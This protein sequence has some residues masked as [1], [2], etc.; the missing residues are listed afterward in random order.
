ML[1]FF[2]EFSF[3]EG[4]PSTQQRSQPATGGTST[5]DEEKEGDNVVDSFEPTYL[6]DA[7]RE[8][9]QLKPLL[10]GQ[11][12]DAEDGR[13]SARPTLE[14]EVEEREVSQPGL[15]EVEVKASWLI[16]STHLSHVY[17]GGNSVHMT[18][19]QTSPMLPHKTGDRSTS[20]SSTTRYAPFKTPS[21]HLTTAVRRAISASGLG[22]ASQQVFIQPLPPVL[23]LHLNRFRYDAAAGGIT[24]IG[25]SIQFGPELE[26]PLDIMVPTSQRPSEPPHYKLYGVL[27]HNG[28]SAGR[29]HY[30]V[31]VLHPNGDGDTGEVWLHIDDE[32]VT[33]TRHEDVFGEDGA[34]R[35]ADERCAYLLFYCRTSL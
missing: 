11:Q 33:R 17:L 35:A 28:E 1:R 12:Q 31:D 23:V 9:R 30:M 19:L 20:T 24:K 5:A 6:Y 4:S 29:G 7:M 21:Q 22:N 14:P 25:K 2:K 3:G 34:E 18:A 32:T 26:I 16:P 8:K 27:Y 13:Q 15:T 10:D